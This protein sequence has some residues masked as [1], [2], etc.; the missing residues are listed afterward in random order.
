MTSTPVRVAA[1]AGGLALAF[2]AA[3]AVG[4]AAT[5][6]DR[7]SDQ[8]SD[9]MGGTAMMPTQQEAGPLPGLAVSEAGYTFVPTA[10]TLARGRSV[11]FAFTIVGPTGAPLTA[12]ETTH[13]KDLHLIVVR[14]DLTGFQH[15]HPT[16][17]DD[18]TW[19][20]PLDVN[21]GGTYR[22]YADFQPAGRDDTLTLGVD[23]QVPGA[24]DPVALPAPATRTMVDGYEVTLRG[25]PQ[26][27]RESYLTFTVARDGEPV[28]TLEP[29]LGAFGHLVSLRTG[30]LAYLHTHPATDAAP[31][32]VGGPDVQFMTEFAT[33][34][35]YRLFLDFSAGGQVHTAEFTLAVG[36]T[37]DAEPSEAATSAPHMGGPSTGHAH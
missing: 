11:P 17:D 33:A 36:A 1:F 18:G 10:T 37:D 30:D 14:R 34:G 2:G 27:G 15:V 9:E 6:Y 16:R 25:A 7:G 5:S 24:F 13:T 19:S 4:A 8:H 28:E 26:A 21:A 22:A 3:F 23:L 20:V 32:D 29:Y 35:S 31:G 12:Y